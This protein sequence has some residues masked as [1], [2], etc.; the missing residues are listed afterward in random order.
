[1]LEIQINMTDFERWDVIAWLFWP[2]VS[3]GPYLKTA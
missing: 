1:M 3:E 2:R